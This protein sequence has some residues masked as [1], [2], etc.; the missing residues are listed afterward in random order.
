MN[1][2]GSKNGKTVMATQRTSLID[3]HPECHES[4]GS[5]NLEVPAVE[6]NIVIK[7]N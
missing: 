2:D 3:H 1:P 4:L 7:N 5:F 6:K